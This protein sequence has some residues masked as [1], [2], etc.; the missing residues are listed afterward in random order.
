MV[1]GW[2]TAQDK[3]QNLTLY[4]EGPAADIFKDVDDLASTAYEDIW[5]QLSRRFGY[6][7]APRDARDAMRRSD[8][9]RQQDN[10]SLQEFE[11]VLRLLQHEAWP[12]KTQNKETLNSNVDL[13]TAYQTW[14]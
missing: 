4:L 11:Q 14:K 3:A 7:D 13:R 12:T 6:T 8:S 10:E 5:T 2:T 1:N 9:R